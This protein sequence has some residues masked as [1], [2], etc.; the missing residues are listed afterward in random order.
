[1]AFGTRRNLATR[2]VVYGTLCAIACCNNGQSPFVQAALAQ[3]TDGTTPTQLTSNQIEGEAEASGQSYYYTFTGG[4]GD[5][6]IKLD[7]ETD[8]YS[9]SAHV[10]LHDE[11]GVELGK[12]ALN[13]TGNSASKSATMHLT[14][15][16]VIKM[17]IMLGVNVGIH[18]KYKVSLAGP[19]NLQA[20]PTRLAGR[21][22]SLQIASVNAAPSQSIS[23]PGA[24]SGSESKSNFNTDSI[25]ISNSSPNANRDS[26]T[27]SN[28]AASNAPIE[29]KWAFVVG[30]SKFAKP[31][32]NLKYPAKDAKDLSNYLINEANFAPDHVKLLVDEQATKERVLAE[33]GDKWLPRLAHPNDLVLIFISTHGSPSQAD[34]EGLN[35]LVMH[36]T[37]PD[38]LYATGLPLSDLAAAIKQ[39]VHSNRVVLI[40]DA[41]HSGAADTAK[42]LT[43][44]GNIDSAALSQGTGQLI[45]CSSMPNQV[46]WESKRYQN[47]VF[48]HQLIEALRAG[49]PTLSQAFERLKESVQT[50]VLQ[51]RSEL[52]TAVLKSKWKG[53]DLIISAPPTKPRQVPAEFK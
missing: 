10:V 53:N 17:Q 32:I 33:L 19:L 47:G 5:L 24:A 44:V 39:R 29:D 16:Q 20:Y 14:K 12:V 27:S 15:S 4:P 6:T 35:Y 51:D 40:I 46:S 42:G 48:T 34:L 30:V 7:G 11:R 3:S 25:S 13:A 36:N 9:T 18:L 38:S 22:S 49:K 28:S 43:R 26:D 52:Q 2:L 45:I 8:F 21:E 31:S 50:E 23:S 37:D 41:C 1:M